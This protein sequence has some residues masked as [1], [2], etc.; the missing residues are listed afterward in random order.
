MRQIMTTGRIDTGDV[1]ADTQQA[2]GTAGIVIW[3]RQVQSP[4]GLR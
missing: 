1:G 4:Q 3:T 2:G